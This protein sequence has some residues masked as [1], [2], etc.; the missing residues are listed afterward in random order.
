M[1]F[2]IVDHHS[3]EQRIVDLKALLSEIDHG[4]SVKYIAQLE[5]GAAEYD[6]LLSNV[7]D[8][9]ARN[10]EGSNV[11]LLHCG[12]NQHLLPEALALFAQVP[13]L[14]Y[15]GGSPPP[16]ID[17]FF[18][19][20]ESSSF[21]AVIHETFDLSGLSEEQKER[22][23]ACVRLILEKPGKP[24]REAVEETFGDPVLEER[25]AQLYD[26]LRNGT[27]IE[28]LV[29]LRNDLLDKEPWE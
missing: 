3:R 11:I 21:H 1:S 18:Q 2:L 4:G 14:L 29:K 23:K 24:V 25:L 17:R 26:A 12:P 8:E 7:A 13:C 19:S 15:S 27:S 9:V 16:K 5:G 6:P 10:V 22:L 28:E 20:A